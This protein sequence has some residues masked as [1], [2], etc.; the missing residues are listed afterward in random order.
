MKAG[1]VGREIGKAL[2]QT[3]LSE[4]SS[5]VISKTLD[6][7]SDT[8]DVSDK[9]RQS[10]EANWSPIEAEM[11]QMFVSGGSNAKRIIDDCIKRKLAN[12]VQTRFFTKMSS[13][14]AP[15]LQG[16][17]KGLSGMGGWGKVVQVIASYAP[18][19]CNLGISLVDLARMVSTFL[20]SLL[21]DLKDAK[22][23]LL[24]SSTDK[25]SAA[26]QTKLTQAQENEF[27]SMSHESREFVVKRVSHTFSQK[28]KNDVLSPLL[29]MGA[30]SLV[31]RAVDG[32]FSKKDIDEVTID[33]VTVKRKIPSRVEQLANDFEMMHAATRPGRTKEAFADKL[34]V[35]VANA[36][37]VRKQDMT[38]EEAAQIYPA[39]VSE[40]ANLVQLYGHHGDEL[41]VFKT[42]DGSYLVKRPDKKGFQA[43]IMGDKPAGDVEQR[44][45]QKVLNC[46][47]SQL[48]CDAEGN[49]K[50]VVKSNEPGSR[51]IELLTKT[52][53]DG[54]KHIGVVQNGQFVEVH[55]QN[56]LMN[57]N[58]CFYNTILVATEMSKGKSFEE[59][60]RALNQNNSAVTDLRKK[61]TC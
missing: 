20:K 51:E 55:N 58:D 54:T 31:S 28:L 4:L 15:A 11:R 52:N 32:L 17:S 36:R 8:Y 33:G 37:P 61:V 59:A 56:S 34:T 12:L 48:E 57:D 41:Q 50:S 47:H 6:A 23:R 30:N 26:T 1:Y 10:V 35:F 29:N 13:K 24:K 19:I 49:Q 46:C 21:A 7:V 9:I 2:V 22:S 42:K 27:R 5:L 44:A 53:A 40:K 45:C 3:G 38:A 14:C 60:T 18:S 39:N 25:S 16:L 43:G